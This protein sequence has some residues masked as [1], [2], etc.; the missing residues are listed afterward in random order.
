[1][2][3]LFGATTAASWVSTI[4]YSVINYFL[5]NAL[6]E[7]ANQTINIGITIINYSQSIVSASLIMQMISLL[8][9]IKISHT[10]L[11]HTP[12]SVITVSVNTAAVG[13]CKHLHCC[14][15]DSSVSAAARSVSCCDQQLHK[16]RV[17]YQRLILFLK[18]LIWQ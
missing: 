5:I 3:F 2:L 14:N 8:K 15:T 4:R 7:N 1:M 10:G 6:L 18:L 12:Q 16:P 9:L 17:I 11:K 13:T